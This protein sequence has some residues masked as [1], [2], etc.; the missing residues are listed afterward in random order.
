MQDRNILVAMRKRN[1][2]QVGDYYILASKKAAFY[3]V[4]LTEVDAYAITK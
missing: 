2:G 1:F 4:A 3:Y